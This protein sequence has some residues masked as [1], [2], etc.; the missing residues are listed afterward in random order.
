M[1]AVF[2]VKPVV[3]PFKRNVSSLFTVYKPNSIGTD[4]EGRISVLSFLGGRISEQVFPVKVHPG[5]LVQAL[6]QENPRLLYMIQRRSIYLL[7]LEKN[8]VLGEAPALMETLNFDYEDGTVLDEER[9]MVMALYSFN[10]SE[11]SLER[12][13]EI[14][15]ESLVSGNTLKK[16]K[17]GYDNPA[18]LAALHAFGRKHLFI[19]ESIEK[20][21]VAYNE[22]LEIAEHV[23]TG[24]LNKNASVSN[25]LS[26]MVVNEKSG[27]AAC[28]ASAGGT[29]QCAVVH[30]KDL[31]KAELS[32]V[33]LADSNGLAPFEMPYLRRFS[34]SPSGRWLFVPVS[35][36][37]GREG[38]Y[39]V[40]IE[41]TNDKS[42]PIPFSLGFD[43]APGSI[44]WMADPEGLVI[45]I[46][47]RLIYWDLSLYNK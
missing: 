41:K 8:I 44:A 45:N 33:P 9:R 18:G 21:W 37:A 30:W 12:T 11:Q 38:C 1:L 13:Y 6:T 3:F 24:Y 34:I 19:R 5:G 31:Q 29:R 26:R 27:T 15:L 22:N 14:R 2:P 17:I 20:P 46:E 43:G 42:V 25:S 4:A 36:G 7:N 35:D 10:A 39:L 47:N 32:V 16:L 40:F 23:L 28:I